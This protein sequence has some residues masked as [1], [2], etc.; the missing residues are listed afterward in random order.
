MYQKIG[1]NV[2]VTGANR[3]IGLG[4][5]KELSKLEEVQHIFACF[6]NQVKIEELKTF[7][8][9]CPKVYIIELDVTNDESIQKALSEIRNILGENSSLN[10]LINNAAILEQ[11][12]VTVQEPNRENFLRHLNTNSLGPVMVNAA[13][14]TLLRNATSLNQPAKIV[15][16]SSL[17]G[18][19]EKGSGT[20]FISAEGSFKNIV[21]GM[22]KCALN[23]YTKALAQEEPSIISIAIC[24]G[25]DHL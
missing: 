25:W 8:E 23:H 16:I 9:Q 17:N 19:I 11:G 24:P 5:V 6:Y 4:L 2:L 20:P 21:Y 1:S 10:L 3:G 14:L 18:S 22:S 13:F 12:G 15:N 7:Q